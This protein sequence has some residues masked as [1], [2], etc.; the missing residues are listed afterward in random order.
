MTRIFI[1]GDTF[2]RGALYN[3]QNVCLWNTCGD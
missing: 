1:L 3:R 2:L